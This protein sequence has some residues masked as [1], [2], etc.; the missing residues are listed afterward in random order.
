MNRKI[1]LISKPI[2]L[3][4]PP[5]NWDEWLQ[6]C[7]GNA[8]FCQSSKWAKIHFEANGAKPYWVDITV[9]GNRKVSALFGFK[10]NNNFFSGNGDLICFHG[11]VLSAGS[12]LE[13]L[14]EL[15]HETERLASDVSARSVSFIGLPSW[16]DTSNDDVIEYI[17]NKSGYKKKPWLTSI[18]D[19]SPSEDKIFASFRNAARKGIRKSER[20]GLT[21]S[22][23]KTFDEFNF[24]FV[25]PYNEENRD[26]LKISRQNT[27]WNL[28][29]GHN[30]NFFFVKNSSD[31]VLATLGT[32]RFNGVATEIMSHRTKANYDDNL[33]AQDILH[34][35]IIKFHKD[36]GDQWFDLAGYSPDPETP[37]EEGIRRFKQKWGGREISI[38]TFTLDLSPFPVRI[39]RKLKRIFATNQ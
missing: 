25:T 8:N 6:E 18:V 9:N 5:R 33:P 36:L 30:Y 29:D 10:A 31:S 20:E 21:V 28:D 13:N 12:N 35:E 3:D 4:S 37:K 32:Y 1:E 16:R 22:Q 39:V 24:C 11:P 26:D 14:A 2:Y 19:L 38:P 23:C 15:L 34:W 27:I 17:F 7:A